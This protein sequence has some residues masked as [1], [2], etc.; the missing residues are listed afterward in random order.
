[1]IGLICLVAAMMLAAISAAMP[2]FG[3]SDR[4]PFGLSLRVIGAICVGL[5]VLGIVL[6]RMGV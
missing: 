2:I 5:A 1:M 6:L 4:P 3:L